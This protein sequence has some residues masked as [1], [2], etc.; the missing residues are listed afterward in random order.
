ME[1]YLTILTEREVRARI[2]RRCA[3]LRKDMC[4]VRKQKKRDSTPRI[5]ALINPFTPKTS[6]VILL[7]VSHTIHDIN[8][9][10]LVL[11]QLIIS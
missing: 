2:L 8:W 4:F 6:Q 11:D 7:T 1:N 5:S 10:N 3:Q 9:E